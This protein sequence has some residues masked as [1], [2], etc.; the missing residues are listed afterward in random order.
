M[1]VC[2]VEGVFFYYGVEE[3]SLVV[4]K[5][6]LREVRV[7]FFVRGVVLGRFLERGDIEVRFERIGRWRGG[8][9]GFLGREDM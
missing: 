6:V 8:R 9:E 1:Y 7:I 3:V 5:V 2:C 4:L